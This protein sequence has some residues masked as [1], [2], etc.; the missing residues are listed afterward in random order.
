[1]KAHATRWEGSF[2]PELVSK[3]LEQLFSRDGYE[4]TGS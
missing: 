4:A 2:N 3:L 1:M